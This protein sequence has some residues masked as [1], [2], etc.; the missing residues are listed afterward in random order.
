MRKIFAFA[1]AAAFLLFCQACGA[2]GERSDADEVIMTG[3]TLTLPTVMATDE[4]GKVITTPDGEPSTY[5]P[6]ASQSGQVVKND[7]NAFPVPNTARPYD[8]YNPGDPALNSTTDHGNG[9]ITGKIAW[10]VADLPS[11]LPAATAYIDRLDLSQSAD[12]IE[13]T[14]TVIE[15]PYV[16]FLRYIEQLQAAGIQS[17]TLELPQ[18]Q[19]SGESAIFVGTAG[20]YTISAIWQP[21]DMS[22]FTANFRLKIESNGA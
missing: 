7:W 5:Y 15:M 14:V 2:T 17:Q 3:E 4:N 16:I 19:P 12:K 21:S 8:L 1:L 6:A 18:A 10:P 22:H 20:I 9:M 13:Q 11:A